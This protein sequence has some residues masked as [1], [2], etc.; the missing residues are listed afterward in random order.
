MNASPHGNRKRTKFLEG[1]ELNK[2]CNMVRHKEETVRLK[3]IDDLPV[4]ASITHR[5]DVEQEDEN[6]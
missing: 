6:N 1:V 3:I 2:Y 4:I 5:F